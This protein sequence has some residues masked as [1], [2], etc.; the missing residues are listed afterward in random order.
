MKHKE[1]EEFG[2]LLGVILGNV[3]EVEELYRES[4][5]YLQKI[6]DLIQKDE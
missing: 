4:V 6:Y 3:R 2:E 1:E 5:R